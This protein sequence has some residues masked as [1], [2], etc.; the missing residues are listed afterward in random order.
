MLCPWPVDIL[1]I[2]RLAKTMCKRD[3]D[4]RFKNM[5]ARK[6]CQKSPARSRIVRFRGV[7]HGFVTRSTRSV[8][9]LISGPLE[10]AW[11]GHQSG[12]GRT[13]IFLP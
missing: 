10:E 13:V 9:C 4:F 2:W 6:I 3:G 8:E 5:F 7:H 12:G 11:G 1:Y